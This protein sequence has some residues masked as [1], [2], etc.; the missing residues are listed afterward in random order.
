MPHNER[1]K[2][3]SDEDQCLKTL[4]KKYG[5][6]N[7]KNVSDKMNEK[8]FKRNSKQCRERWINQLDPTINHSPW[9]DS[10]IKHFYELYDKIGNHWCEISKHMPG[11]PENQVKQYAH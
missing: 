6:N 7:W 3:T 8:K 2:W 4:I 10:E 11:R 9:T 5:K 1:K